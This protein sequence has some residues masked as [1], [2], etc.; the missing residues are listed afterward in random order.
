M[1]HHGAFPFLKEIILFLT[2]SGLLI[3]LLARL[4]INPVLGFLAVG[5]LLGPYGL[6]SLSGQWPWLGYITFARLEDVE[7]LAELGVIFLMFMIGLEMSVNRLWSMR[8]LVFGMGGLQVGL[9]ALL[10]GA[11]AWS[12]GNRLEASVILG[13][14]LAFSSTAIVMQLL[15]QRRALGSPLGQA[16]FSIL[17]FQDLAV[18]PLLVLIS[19]L[20][21][22]SGGDSFGAMLGAAALKGVLTVLAIY[23]VG[24]R[25]VRP[26]F[27]QIAANR[28][29]DTFMAL[30][31]LATLGVAALTW[32]AGLSMALGALL[33]GLI[34]AETEFRHQVEVTMEPF[35]G[36]MMGLFFLSVGMGIDTRAVLDAPLWMPLS[37][38]GLFLLK[39]V[40][41]FGLLRVFGLSRGRSLEGG[42]L[43]SQGGEFAFIV[44]GLALSFNLLPRDVGQFMLIVVGLSMLAA[45]LVAHLGRQLGDWLERR[46]VEKQ[47]TGEAEFG[48]LQGHVIIAGFGRV[49]QMV[50]Q[51]L[52]AQGLRFVAIEQD[53]ALLAHHRRQ[54]VPIVFG[55]A[56]RPELLGKLHLASARAVVLTMDNTAAAV[57]AVHAVR[58]VAPE[59]HITA[60][61]RDESH[62]LTLLEAGATQVVP[63]TL[64][65]S[66]KVADSVLQ[67]MGVA[68]ELSGELL[69]QERQRCLSALR[70]A[71]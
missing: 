38:I 6:A 23:L 26:L 58:Q 5:T 69:A 34:I 62:A 4:R 53:A 41:I 64:E 44:I 57:H 35:R 48:D 59:V 33:A 13:F 14:L 10:I 27:H 17:L 65:S 1:D 50:G 20:G 55:D 45:P 71:R 43:L 7:V 9:T 31:L 47:V 36:L 52:A 32:V 46:T 63:E 30:T 15:N 51:L 12:F 24:R 3:P 37:V 18:I 39:G 56:S 22:G 29:P 60:R 28:Q 68:P 61:A 70:E 21:A 16:S 40:I 67:V 66:L 54:G 19:I 25:L 11:I 2:L 49:G 8:K 42:L